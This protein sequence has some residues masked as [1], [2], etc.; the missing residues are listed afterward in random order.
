[1]D[2]TELAMMLES[3]SAQPVSEEEFKAAAD[4]LQ[5]MHGMKDEEKLQFYGLYKQGTVGNVNTKKPSFFD[6]VG[7][8][9]W[10][11]WKSYEGFPQESAKMAYVYL[12]EKYARDGEDEEEE[13]KDGKGEPLGIGAGRVVSTFL[14]PLGYGFDINNSNAYLHAFI[15]SILLHPLFR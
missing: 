14:N 1:M 5:D 4:S 15:F 11:S 9:K 6:F 8:K 2:V 13:G 7:Q 3:M 10:D 12:V